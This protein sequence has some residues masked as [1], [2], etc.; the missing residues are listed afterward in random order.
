MSAVG[1]A[2]IEEIKKR[3]RLCDYLCV[4]ELFLQDNF[5]LTRPLEF[6][7]IK[8]RLL[9]H[10]GTCHGINVAYAN[11]KGH[12]GNDPEFSFVL[13][14]GH[15]FPALQAN[16]WL[17]GE[18]SKIDPKATLDKNGIEY[19]CK[20]Y[21]DI[22]GFWFDGMW[23][24]KDSDWE[25]DAL[26]G[27]IRKWQP[28]AIIINN[29]GL[30]K[31]GE[32]GHIE[33][34][35]VTFERGKP[36]PINLSTSPKYIASEMCQVFCDHWGYA[37]NDFNYKSVAEIIETLAVCRRY[38]SNF[39]LNIGPMADGSLRTIDRGMLEIVGKWVEIN[40]EAIYKPLPTQITVD[41]K[42]KDFI[43]QDGNIYYLFVH[44]LKMVADTNVALVSNLDLEEHFLF[45]KTIKAVHWID[46]NESLD[47]TQKNG[48]A[49]IY[50]KPF[51]YGESQVVR[52]AKIF[53]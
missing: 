18:L 30:S 51:L 44:D 9:G 53:T 26:Y 21:G 2:K 16:L 34:D 39:L 19:L 32:L 37:K 43:L 5:L 20:N 23:D 6:N 25:E 45:D 38:R 17:D 50:A 33:L 12:F 14:P 52:I 41:N 7:D 36:K 46:N 47:F 10:W 4:A 29:T 48:K 42:P 22:G 24:K 8:P 28:N 40:K 3:V 1:I 13:G 11:L 49:T 31:L 15:G 35:S 27:L